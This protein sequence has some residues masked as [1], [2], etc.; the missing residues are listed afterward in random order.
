MDSQ[1]NQ[2]LGL[3]VLLVSPP[4]YLTY[5]VLTVARASRLEWKSQP[6]GGVS[7]YQGGRY[8]GPGWGFTKQDVESGRVARLPA[9]IDAID[10]ACQRHDQCY[11][12]HGYF[13]QR[14]NV[15]LATELTGVI[16][17]MSSTPQQRY[18]AA[19]MAAIFATEAQVDPALKL[20]HRAYQGLERYYRE[21]LDSGA[22]FMFAIEQGIMRSAQ[23]QQP[24]Y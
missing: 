20:G 21:L 9:A 23:F 13:T 1:N 24:H 5:Q 6:E 7:T 12:D 15:Q 14:C 11:Q 10:E 3:S 22:Q 17:S 2:I 18:D 8:C 19:L 16:V 4:T